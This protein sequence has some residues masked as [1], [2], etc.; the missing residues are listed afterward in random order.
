MSIS[1]IFHVT[2][3]CGAGKSHHTIIELH[4]HLVKNGAKLDKDS[5]FVVASKTN[6]LSEQNYRKFA[7][8]A[9]TSQSNV[10]YKLINSDVSKNVIKDI[11]LHL[12]QHKSGVLFISHEAAATLTSGELENT[13]LIFDEV[14]D[15]LV[16]EVRAQHP[17]KEQGYP[18]ERFLKTYAQ[19][20]SN[21]LLVTLDPAIPRSEISDQIDNIF[22]GKDTVSSR[23]VAK[24]FQF[25]LDG[26]ENMYMTTKDY[27]NDSYN[28][29]TGISW[30][31]LDEL[32]SHAKSVVVL[33]AELK[34]TLLGYV[35]ENVAKIPIQEVNVTDALTLDTKHRRDVV[36]Y[37]LIENKTWS[38]HLKKRKAS[39]ALLDSK[40]QVLPDETVLE[41]FLRVVSA[42]LG[43]DYL[44]IKNN[45]DTFSDALIRENVE[46]ISSSS[47]GSNNYMHFHHGAYLSSKRPDP[48][49]ETSYKLFSRR[50]GL[51]EQDLIN[52]IVTERCYE[53]AYQCLARTSIRDPNNKFQ[54]PHQLIV[55][56][57]EYA[58]YIASWFDQG[59]ATIDTS[60]ACTVLGTQAMQDK[61]IKD[62]LRIAQILKDKLAGKGTI[63]YLVKQAGISMGT[64]ENHRKLYKPQLQKDGLIK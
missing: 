29:Y 52:C 4:K 41:N 37:P 38:S 50:Y 64:Y 7:E 34:R 19:E 39:E 49:E 44:L 12:S 47:H 51:K 57:M 24:L 1:S 62:Y 45:K 46:I 56:D 48:T 58:K 63:K 32:R 27:K 59:Y 21:F 8:E 28:Y 40:V 26:H 10:L 16:F 61:Q 20:G 60:L 18:W 33:S 31:R 13:T 53:S 42:K 36:I 25:L 55:P 5:F 14:P 2:S 17:A 6:A 54:G 23:Q 3:C 43:N 11:S 35:A 15:N 22:K 30:K 9:K